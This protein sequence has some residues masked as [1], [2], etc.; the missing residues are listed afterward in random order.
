MTNPSNLPGD[1]K[2][3]TPSFDYREQVVAAWIKQG[4]PLRPAEVAAID[5]LSQI[6]IAHKNKLLPEQTAK[7]L[8]DDVVVRYTDENDEWHYQQT[9]PPVGQEPEMEEQRSCSST[10]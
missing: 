7:L 3:K 6:N 2:D 5:M 8:Y 1:T 9:M 4:I 10:V